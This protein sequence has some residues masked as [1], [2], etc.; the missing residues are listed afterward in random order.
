VPGI[1]GGW[2]E[3]LL[4]PFPDRARICRKM[5]HRRAVRSCDGAW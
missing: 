3:A 4:F 1:V 2:H 5:L